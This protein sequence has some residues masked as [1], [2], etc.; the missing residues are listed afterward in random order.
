MDSLVLSPQRAFCH[1]HLTSLT[2]L[3]NFPGARAPSP[4]LLAFPR[5]LLRYHF[6]VRKRNSPPPIVKPAVKLEVQPQTLASDPVLPRL[7]VPPTQSVGSCWEIVSWMNSMDERQEKLPSSRSLRLELPIESSLKSTFAGGLVAEELDNKECEGIRRVEVPWTCEYR[8]SLPMSDPHSLASFTAGSR[9]TTPTPTA[10]R[11]VWRALTARW[12]AGLHLILIALLTVYG[13]RPCPS[14]RHSLLRIT[15]SDLLYAYS[16]SHSTRPT[17]SLLQLTIKHNQ[18][19]DSWPKTPS[20]NI[21][22]IFCQERC[23]KQP[24]P[25]QSLV[26]RRLSF[27]SSIPNSKAPRLATLPFLQALNLP[28]STSTPTPIIHNSHV[29]R[30]KELDHQFEIRRLY[31]PMPPKGCRYRGMEI[32]APTRH[33]FRTH[34]ALIFDRKDLFVEFPEQAVTILGASGH[35]GR[36][37]CTSVL[38]LGHPQGQ[39]P[40]FAL[41]ASMPAFDSYS[42]FN[43]DEFVD[44]LNGQLRGLVADVCVLS[45]WPGLKQLNSDGE[46]PQGAVH[47]FE[48]LRSVDTSLRD[49]S[50][51]DTTGLIIRIK[52]DFPTVDQT[53]S[54]SSTV[55][56]RL[57]DIDAL[58]TKA[59]TS[60]TLHCVLV[61]PPVYKPGAPPITSA[62]FRASLDA[63]PIL[64]NTRLENVH[65]ALTFTRNDESPTSLPS[66]STRLTLAG[67][68]SLGVFNAEKPWV[69]D[70][71][72]TID[73]GDF[74]ELTVERA[75]GE[76]NIAQLGTVK[77]TDVKLNIRWTF[78]QPSVSLN[79]KLTCEVKIGERALGGVVSFQG[80]RPSYLA[81]GCSE[82]LQVGEL[83]RAFVASSLPKDFINLTLSKVDFCYSW[84]AEPVVVEK[85][86]RV[87]PGLTASA[88]VDLF[89]MVFN[90]S[91]TFVPSGKEKGIE[92]SAKLE[93][94]IDLS[95]VALYE[96]GKVRSTSPSTVA[97]PSSVWTL[98]FDNTTIRYGER[99]AGDKQACLKVDVDVQSPVVSGGHHR[100]NLEIFKVKDRTHVH[101][102][103]VSLTG[104]VSVISDALLLDKIR[105]LTRADPCKEIDIPLRDILEMTYWPKIE[106]SE[107]QPKQEPGKPRR[108]AFDVSIIWSIRV[109]KEKVFNIDVD[110]FPPSDPL[111]MNVPKRWEDLWEEIRSALAK[112]LDRLA[113]HLLDN[114][115]KFSEILAF[116]AARYYAE[117]WMK[118]AL[119]AWLCRHSNASVPKPESEEPETVPSNPKPASS[120]SPERSENYEELV[121]IISVI[122]E[123][124]VV[125]PARKTKVNIEREAI[126]YAQVAAQ[127]SR[128]RTAA[129]PTL[130]FEPLD[131]PSKS[132]RITGRDREIGKLAS[133][134]Q[135]AAYIQQIMAHQPNR[136]FV[137][138]ALISG[139]YIQLLHFDRSGGQITR[140]IDYHERPDL[141]LHLI[142]GLCS[143]DEADVGFDKSIEWTINESGRKASGRLRTCGPDKVQW[144]P[145]VSV[146]PIIH[147]IGIR[148]RATTCWVVYDPDNPEE[149][150]LVKDSWNA[151]GR[152]LEHVHFDNAKDIIGLA[153]K[154]SDE[155]VRITVEEFRCSSTHG[156]DL[157]GNRENTR[158]LFKAYGPRLREFRSALQLLLAIRD[159][160]AAHARLLTKGIL[161]RDVS[162]NNMLLGIPTNDLADGYRGVLIDLGVA[163]DL[164]NA[165][166]TLTKEARTG[167]RFHQ[168]CLILEFLT[169]ESI[170]DAPA[171]DYLDDLEGFFF[172]MCGMFF[173]KAP[174]GSDLP[175][176]HRARLVVKGW[177]SESAADALRSKAILFDSA[178]RQKD[179]ASLLVQDTWRIPC[180]KLFD[181]YR[182][183]VCRI[184]E[185]KALL[186]PPPSTPPTAPVEQPRFAE[187]EDGSHPFQLSVF[188]PLY[189]HIQTHYRDIVGLFNDAVTALMASQPPQLPSYE[190]WFPGPATIS[191]PPT[192]HLRNHRSGSRADSSLIS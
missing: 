153:K 158:I 122:L 92:A 115:D 191:I 32:R 13:S 33:S 142:V 106:F 103:G 3:Q 11:A 75:N 162:E 190:P 20:Y 36:S 76:H 114:V 113:K 73:T 117:K 157:F 81:F 45:R 79:A 37:E 96:K 116:L 159:I 120:Q 70:G 19:S 65:L 44:G 99:S 179:I 9:A 7:Y 63:F 47:A 130:S 134:E 16:P 124:L 50:S 51:T 59:L 78:G 28:A 94:P 187:Q 39:P 148:G 156:Q 69:S 135:S 129:R 24:A 172:V 104:I 31:R 107:N 181:G 12:C 189:A 131:H 110:F 95:I 185:E 127:P 68:L 170:G 1:S 83:F 186:L 178:R 53:T 184:Q 30:P 82:P 49:S 175:P 57:S 144:Y 71:T 26:E 137:R 176:D 66:V 151:E 8:T 34:S 169:E 164:I 38:Y 87:E 100:V 91:V 102:N 43:G 180:Q 40:Y 88:Q 90:A 18:S 2:S 35:W 105:E 160:I 145:L 48:V 52:V 41:V 138:S 23:F 167:S 72:L 108:C 85:Q 74:A 192:R 80:M 183:W 67:R 171:H 165:D 101:L 121:R 146:E 22:H 161:H 25:C 152:T 84:H 136:W 174:D 29:S 97:S 60:L 55:L 89:G 149:R 168:S 64:D 93:R 58:A 86:R 118:Q 173:Q 177:D 188:S 123:D 150:L 147:Q 132:L 14:A 140:F 112:S 10:M 15:P 125:S 54:P 61:K 62:T 133:R 163:L 139:R 182:Q 109:L 119:R 77:I 56:K 21:N 155:G 98:V 46:I 154:I 126:G 4:S 27:I 143:A 5:D 6:V 42:I 111:V 166:A 128:K 17:S 141:F